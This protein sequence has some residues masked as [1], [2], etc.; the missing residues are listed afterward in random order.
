MV[1]NSRQQAAGS[2]RLFPPSTIYQLLS[3][4]C[5]LLSTS[6]QLLSTSYHTPMIDLISDNRTELTRLCREFGVRK[7]EVF[8]SAA[9]GEFN[10]ESSDVDFLIEIEEGARSS[11]ASMFDF[12]HAAAEL[13]GR[14][15]DVVINTRFRNPYFQ[16][17]VDESRELVWQHQPATPA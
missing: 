13:L 15:V 12:Q 4:S 6:C 8:G 9:T 7:L 17:A 11:F 2:N 5:Q 3:T 14:E 1:R 16:E 10:P